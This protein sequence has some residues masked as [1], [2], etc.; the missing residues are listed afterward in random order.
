MNYK[1]KFLDNTTSSL[2]FVSWIYCSIGCLGGA[3]LGF[4]SLGLGGLVIGL[5]GGTFLGYVLRKLTSQ[6]CK[7]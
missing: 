2:N 5:T 6:I 4:F 1:K 3:A 7:L